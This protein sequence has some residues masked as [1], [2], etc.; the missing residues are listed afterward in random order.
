MIHEPE[1]HIFES[2]KSMIDGFARLWQDVA[3]KALIRTGRFTAAL[4]GGRT[5]VPFLEALAERISETIW[6]NTHIFLV[7][8]RHVPWSDPDSNYGMIRKA[9]VDKLSISDANLH[10]VPYEETSRQSAH[11]YESGLKRFFRGADTPVLDLIV[12]GLGADGHT[13]SLFPKDAALKE[14]V[15]WVAVADPN[16]AP[17]ERITLTVPVLNAGK[18]VVFVVE[19]PDKSGRVEEIIRKGKKTLPASKIHPRNGRLIW[20]LDRKAAAYISE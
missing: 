5:P 9:L 20:L 3:R 11:A 19:G 15:R 16:E 1:I 2:K 12:L 7:D 14:M 10:P 4:S 13:A 17:H 18:N 6:Q 8:E